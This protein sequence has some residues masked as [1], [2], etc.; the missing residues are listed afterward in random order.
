MEGLK[1]EDEQCAAA[2]MFFWKVIV[3]REERTRVR[4]NRCAFIT[5]EAALFTSAFESE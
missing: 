5:K 2:Q 3:Q 1:S 4:I